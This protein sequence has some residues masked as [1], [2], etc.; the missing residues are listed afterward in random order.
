MLDRNDI[1]TSAY[2]RDVDRKEREYELKLSLFRQDPYSYCEYN[3]LA[4]S[5]YDMLNMCLEAL[6]PDFDMEAAVEYRE[7]ACARKDLLAAIRDS[8]EKIEL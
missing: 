3:I 6:L 5:I 8:V 1:E 7:N 2:E 4:F